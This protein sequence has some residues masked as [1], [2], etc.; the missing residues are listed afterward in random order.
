MRIVG[1][2]LL[3]DFIRQHADAKGPIQTWIAL[4]RDAT[5][6]KPPDVRHMSGSASFL[7]DRKV[8]FNIKGNSYRLAVKVS[9]KKQIVSVVWI[10][11]HTEY[12]KWTFED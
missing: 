6:Q 12:D 7:G 2:G 11:T 5:W 10:G 1:T 4:V 9:Y 8:I 3:Y